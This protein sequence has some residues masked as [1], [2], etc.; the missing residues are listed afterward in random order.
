[1]LQKTPSISSNEPPEITDV[2]IV[3]R[4]EPW[5]E[6][7]LELRVNGRRISILAEQKKAFVEAG[8]LVYNPSID[9]PGGPPL[10]PLTLTILGKRADYPCTIKS[11]RI[12]RYWQQAVELAEEGAGQEHEDLVLETGPFK[13]GR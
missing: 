12:M 5:K 3:W 7:Q 13:L 2:R 1:M 11:A 8:A 4:G 10:P 9:D 6:P